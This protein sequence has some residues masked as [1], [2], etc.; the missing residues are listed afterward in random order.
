MLASTSCN[1]VGHLS[2]E[3]HHYCV[4]SIHCALYM[5]ETCGQALNSVKGQ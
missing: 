3:P 4:Y 2:G 5:K 1:R